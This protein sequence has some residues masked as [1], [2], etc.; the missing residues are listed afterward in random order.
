MPPYAKGVDV[1]SPAMLGIQT[2]WNKVDVQV[3]PIEYCQIIPTVCEMVIFSGIS[4]FVFSFVS[5]FLCKHNN[6]WTSWCI[7]Q[8]SCLMVDLHHI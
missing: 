6:I 4:V 3:H 8:I 5:M 7:Y 1:Y 2:K